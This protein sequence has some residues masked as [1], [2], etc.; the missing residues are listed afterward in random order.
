MQIDP[1]LT[2]VNRGYR[3]NIQAIAAAQAFNDD[4]IPVAVI[5]SPSDPRSLIDLR[6]EPDDSALYL[7]VQQ[8]TFLDT[9]SFASIALTDETALQLLQA[10]H[11]WLIRKQQA[12]QAA[13]LA[14]PSV[15]EALGNV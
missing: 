5:E 6:A 12:V 14:E 2:T 10:V 9:L 3:P 13:A 1:I 15:M 8:N 7:N 11:G 4:L